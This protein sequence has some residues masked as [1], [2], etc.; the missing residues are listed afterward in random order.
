M[1]LE[2]KGHSSSGGGPWILTPAGWACD[3]GLARRVAE[4]S[5][6]TEWFT[7]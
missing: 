4:Y 7:D 1:L 6:Q 3:P 5:R 2:L